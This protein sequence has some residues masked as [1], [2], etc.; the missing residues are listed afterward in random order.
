MTTSD[1]TAQGEPQPLQS[2]LNSSNL[3]LEVPVAVTF[4]ITIPLA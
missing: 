3:P 2:K 4:H 1:G